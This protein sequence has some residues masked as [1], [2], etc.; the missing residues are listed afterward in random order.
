[1]ASAAGGA[2]AGPHLADSF[3]IAS[4]IATDEDYARSLRSRT[5]YRDALV[6]VA[7]R[8]S[9]TLVQAFEKREPGGGVHGPRE[10]GRKAAEV[11]DKLDSEEGIELLRARAAFLDEPF[12][13]APLFLA[14]VRKHA[15]LASA[16]DG[17]KP[18]V[19]EARAIAKERAAIDKLRDC[20]RQA[21]L[22]MF[23]GGVGMTCMDG[24]DKSG[25]EGF[26][27][28]PFLRAM[29][30]RWGEIVPALKQSKPG[31]FF[32]QLVEC[33]GVTGPAHVDRL[34]DRLQSASERVRFCAHLHYG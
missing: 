20:D 11:A 5:D 25:A 29:R 8:G 19:A 2:D 3:F 15:A 32:L 34:I 10:R 6:G 1:M 12:T 33:Y 9:E 23:D 21:W 18:E 26:D 28:I 24:A 13:Y 4:V 16:L 30:A 27:P 14:T 17:L 31:S 7:A 22:A